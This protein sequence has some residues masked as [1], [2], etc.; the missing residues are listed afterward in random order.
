VRVVYQDRFEWV[1]EA[2][3]RDEAVELEVRRPDGTTV[4]TERLPV[5]GPDEL[6]ALLREAVVA[7]RACEEG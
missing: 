2:T 3:V 4:R 1:A 6:R 5:A 7:S